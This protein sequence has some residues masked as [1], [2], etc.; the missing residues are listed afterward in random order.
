MEEEGKKEGEE[1]EDERGSEAVN[2]KHGWI[3][4][5]ALW[6][7]ENESKINQCRRDNYWTVLTRGCA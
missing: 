2:P 3:S 4:W 6:S 1:E 5:R 7:E